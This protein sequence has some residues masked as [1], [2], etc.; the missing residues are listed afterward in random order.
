MSLEQVVK[1]RFCGELYKFYPFSAADQSACP[2]CV[3]KA[4]ENM[5]KNHDYEGKLKQFERG[6]YKSEPQ[7]FKKI[8]SQGW[9]EQ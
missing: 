4:E 8:N 1:C 5:N 7:P 6:P 9:F 2:S 3:K